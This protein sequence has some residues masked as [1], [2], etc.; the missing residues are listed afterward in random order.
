MGLSRAG[1]HGV[2]PEDLGPQSS[3]PARIWT[4]IL[5]PVSLGTLGRLA[6]FLWSLGMAMLIPMPRLLA[7]AVACLLVGAIVYPRA[8]RRILRPRWLLWMAMLAVPSLFFLPP[9][10]STFLG[11]S[12]SSA[13]LQAAIQISL[14]FMIVLIAVQGFT[15]A[16]DV[17]ELAG[18]LER[19]G[20][21][22]LGFSVGVAL[23]LL[24]GLQQSGLDAWR[25]L[26]M[27]GGL[28]RQWRRGL[29]LLAVTIVTN[30]LRLA[31]DVALAAEARAFSPENARPMPIQKG[32]LDWPVF[33]ACALSILLFIV[34]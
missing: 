17:P 8:L 15:D 23:N 33:A 14:R 24:P 21:H 27:R 12:Y 9:L 3:R 31:E 30:A 1:A 22:G 26:R 2:R 25:A 16:V 19:L 29:R 7:A 5:R 11:I 10:D 32:T 13:G 28:R 4:H 20:M 34:L 18:L 6:L